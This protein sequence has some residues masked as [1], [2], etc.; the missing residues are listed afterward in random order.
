M[1]DYAA[2]L[3]DAKKK[4]VSVREDAPQ[5]AKADARQVKNAAGGFAFEVDDW[6][7]L[8]RFL[9]LGA[10]GGTFHVGEQKLV[11]EGA[12][13]LERCLKDDASA[14]IEH[15]AAISESG[16]AP[17]NDPAI[18]A[19]AVAASHADPVV[20]RLALAALPRVCRIG[21]HIFQFAE[22]VQQ[23]RGWGAGLRRAVGAWYT[24]KEG[25]DL[26]YQL[27]KYQQRGGVSHRDLLR[28]SHPK[29]KDPIVQAILR[30][31]IAG[32]SGLGERSVKRKQQEAGVSYEAVAAG[33]LPKVIEG[34]ERVKLATTPEECAALVREYN[35]THEMVP[36]E[37][38]KHAV[39]WD[40][41]L[42][43]MPMHAMVRNLG[44][45]TAN[46]LLV[47]GSD[48]AKHVVKQL[49]NE[50]AIK[51]SRMHPLAVLMALRTYASGHGE[52]GKLTWTAVKPIIDAL[53]DAFYAA[54]E[55]VEP[56]GKSIMLALDVS[57]SMAGSQ[58]AGTSLTAREAVACMAMVTARREPD[59][60]LVGFT[61]GGSGYG[62]R[63]GG[64]ASGLSPVA[65]TA[66]TALSDA[67]K[68]ME[69]MSMGGTDCALPMLHALGKKQKVEAF[70][71]YT[72]NETW[73]GAVHPFKAI[74]Q[75]REQMGIPAK[76]VVVGTEAS[77][78]TIA[79]PSDA[80]M[81]DVVGFDSGAPAVIA[82]FIR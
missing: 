81:L 56:T 15:I 21:T 76:L 12:G 51:K 69:R 11:R 7:R 48:A 52:K 38:Q 40:A 49:K 57:G 74:K 62:G 25:G 65:I 64:S 8:D 43:R 9:I 73:A 75:Y 26:A 77:P 4:A 39:V 63:W 68:I 61:A 24:S 60:D 23:L 78:F 46:G 29:S 2:H 1:S 28:L 14:A 30:W 42:Q 82:D 67:C 13:A 16:R 3:G 19:L 20:R 72:D 53:D 37:Q 22:Q 47:P 36:S 18:F 71:V 59:Y 27:V 10:E 54:F 44:R 80:G 66:K 6:K 55:T 41:L 32:S 34:F 45:M 50:A 70:C 31:T 35:L 17:K 79:D 33:A 5:S 58:V